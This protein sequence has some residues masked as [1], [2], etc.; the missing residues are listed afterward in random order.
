MDES[1]KDRLEREKSKDQGLAQKMSELERLAQERLALEKLG[2]ERLAQESLLQEKLARD[3]LEREKLEQEQILQE[4]LVKENLEREKLEQE[5]LEKER[6]EKQR[7]ENKL[8]PN[9][10]L[11]MIPSWG[12]LL[13]YPTLGTYLHHK[14]SKIVTDTV[15]FLCGYDY[16]IAVS[17]THLTL[18]TTPYV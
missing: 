15:I 2:Q 16:S 9:N 6:M 14:V 3:K 4:R 11:F 1:E 13:G 12:D 7:N 18:P 10:A 8:F 5:R 17:Y